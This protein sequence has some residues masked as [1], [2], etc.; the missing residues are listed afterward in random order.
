M[1]VAIYARVS[2]RDK[3]QNPET[4]LLPL[5]ETVQRLGL[6]VFKVY[7][8]TASAQDIAHRTA[9][10]DLLDDAARRRF[11]VVLVFKLDRA[12]RSVKHMHDT[13]HAWDIVG[14]RF[15]SIREDYDTTTAHG[16]LL[17][18]IL[19][20]MAEFEGELIRERVTAG[21]RRAAAS[22]TKSGKPIGRPR[23]RVNVQKLL[24]AYK[25]CRSIRG[26]AQTVGCTSGTAFRRLRD[27]GILA[28]LPPLSAGGNGKHENS[29]RGSG[30]QKGDSAD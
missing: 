20:S 12:F 30:V 19:G 23:A 17:L 22:G 14:V 8:D 9:W 7:V 27:D 15:Q 4:Q 2:T 10:R 18:N 21:M 28:E 1:K 11:G 29:P 16:R 13:L 5:R 25:R 26:A 3:D 6:E 24:N